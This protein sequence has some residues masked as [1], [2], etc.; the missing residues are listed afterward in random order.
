[1]L[2]S[3]SRPGPIVAICFIWV[4]LSLQDMYLLSKQDLSLLSDRQIIQIVGMMGAGLAA[5]VGMWMMKKWGVYLFTVLFIANQ[6]ILVS[7]NAWQLGT[8][9]IPL[10]II[11]VGAVHLKKMS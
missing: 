5:I 6:V 11:I 2:N 7:Q 9:F 10:L 1:M 3:F 8:T 4:L